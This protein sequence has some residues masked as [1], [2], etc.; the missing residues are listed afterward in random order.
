MANGEPLDAWNG[1][2]GN[3]KGTTKYRDSKLYATWKRLSPGVDLT[4]WD[5]T[6]NVPEGQ[7]KDV[8]SGTTLEYR[9]GDYDNDR[10]LYSR[11]SGSMTGK[12]S[13]VPEKVNG[14]NKGKLKVTNTMGLPFWKRDFGGTYGGSDAN[15]IVLFNNNLVKQWW[16]SVSK[17]E[18]PYMPFLSNRTDIWYLNSGGSASDQMNYYSKIKYDPDEFNLNLTTKNPN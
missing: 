6:D 15:I 1:N 16:S 17:S 13:S 5:S 2:I 11:V 7:T 10:N 12:T 9:Y 14:E 18:G 3:C 4:V 8:G